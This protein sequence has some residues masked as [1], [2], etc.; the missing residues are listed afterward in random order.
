ML[1][2][3]VEATNILQSEKLNN[4]EYRNLW[5]GVALIT[6]NKFLD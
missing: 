6:V 5:M 2:K 3:D 4:Y 1:K